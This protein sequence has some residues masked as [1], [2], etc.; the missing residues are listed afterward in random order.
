MTLGEQRA[1]LLR[2]SIREWNHGSVC[3]FWNALDA[4]E[5]TPAEAWCEIWPLLDSR[6]SRALFAM[7]RDAVVATSRLVTSK[8]GSA[9][10]REPVARGEVVS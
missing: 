1:E 10:W 9:Q 5:M 7:H 6:E 3:A 8:C 2:T 4:G